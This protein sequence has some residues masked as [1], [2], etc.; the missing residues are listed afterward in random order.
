MRRRPKKF[1]VRTLIVQSD[2]DQIASIVDTG[3][4]QSKLI[5]GATLKI[6]E[7]VPH[8]LHTARASQSLC[9]PMFEGHG[10]LRQ[11]FS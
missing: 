7:G 1:G 3:R 2:D 11:T 9:R 10:E 8:G 5:K 4:L 6:F